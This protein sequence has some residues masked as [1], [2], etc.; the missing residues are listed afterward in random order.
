M[1]YENKFCYRIIYRIIFESIVFTYYIKVTEAYWSHILLRW[2]LFVRI[3]TKALCSSLIAFIINGQDEQKKKKY[4]KIDDK[5][6]NLVANYESENEME[7][8]KGISS[9]LHLFQTYL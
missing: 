4:R 3:S 5:I 1:T 9:N 7:F 6:A 2:D 8:L